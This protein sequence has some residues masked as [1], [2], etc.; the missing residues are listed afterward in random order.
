MTGLKKL[1]TRIINN[2]A[3]ATQD[4]SGNVITTTYVK[5]SELDTDIVYSGTK[6]WI[7]NC[8]TSTTVLNKFIGG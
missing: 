3:I 7:F 4:D 6:T 8:V 1:S 5:K 2:H